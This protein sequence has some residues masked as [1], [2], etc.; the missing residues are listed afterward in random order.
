MCVP[1]R[2]LIIE[3]VVLQLDMYEMALTDLGYSVLRATRGHIGYDVSVKEKP[4]VIITDLALPDVDG[5][6]VCAWLTAI[7][8]VQ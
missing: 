8:T 1:K 5:W 4:D 6:V 2:I 3:D 7:V